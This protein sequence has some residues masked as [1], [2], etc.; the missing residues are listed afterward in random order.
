MMPRC[1]PKSTVL[2]FHRLIY[3]LCGQ[4]TVDRNDGVRLL[5][6]SRKRLKNMG[7]YAD[8]VQAGLDLQDCA[9]VFEGCPKN[10]GQIVA[11]LPIKFVPKRR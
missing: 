8:A 7:E 10:L 1:R 6:L 9:A 2:F 11:S 5:S 3:S 4:I